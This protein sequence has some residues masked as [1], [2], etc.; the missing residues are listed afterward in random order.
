MPKT[1]T[2]RSSKATARGRPIPPDD[3]P[4]TA[5]DLKEIRESEEAFRRGEYVTLE[6]LEADVARLRSKQA[7]KKTP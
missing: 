2:T 5:E 3:E 6:E 7:K 4:L 1:A